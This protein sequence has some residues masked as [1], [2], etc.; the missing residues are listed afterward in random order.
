[1][2]IIC[3]FKNVNGYFRIKNC[4]QLILF[5]MIF[6]DFYTLYKKYTQILKSEK[7]IKRK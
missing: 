2:F 6:C 3:P 5:I 1:M 7:T 4:V